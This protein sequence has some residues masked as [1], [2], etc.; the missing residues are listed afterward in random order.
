MAQNTQ[1]KEKQN[2]EFG[3][4]P[5]LPKKYDSLISGMIV[6]GALLLVGL[7]LLNTEFTLW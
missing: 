2:K 4:E 7:V 1:L 6:V 3:I 5:A